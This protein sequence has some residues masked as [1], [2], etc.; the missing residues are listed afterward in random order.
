MRLIADQN[1]HR[2]VV[3]RLREAGYEVE[4]IQETMPGRSDEDLLRRADIG[5]AIFITGDKGFGDWTFNK[6]LPRPRA[7]LLSRLPQPEWATTADR[8]IAC[9]E[10]G[11][12]PGQMVTITKSGE[13][14]KP[15][16]PGAN[17]G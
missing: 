4:H 14:I 2:R 10:R 5:E 8:L 6:G 3:K 12:A 9:L 1:V 17:N 11:I 16:P 7:I 15:F 13:R